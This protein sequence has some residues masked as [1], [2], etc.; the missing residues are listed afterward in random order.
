MGCTYLDLNVKNKGKV[1]HISSQIKYNQLNVTTITSHLKSLVNSDYILFQMPLISL[2][3]RT[4]HVQ[5]KKK[6]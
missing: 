6:S 1:N 5:K 2:N 3:V 4:K